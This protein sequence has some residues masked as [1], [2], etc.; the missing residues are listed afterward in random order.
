MKAIYKLII[1]LA[2]FFG[3]LKVILYRL[4]GLTAGSP[5]IWTTPTGW[6]ISIVLIILLLTVFRI[7]FWPAVKKELDIK[8]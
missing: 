5:D 3:L 6:I 7:F 4:G 2:I 8:K 1:G